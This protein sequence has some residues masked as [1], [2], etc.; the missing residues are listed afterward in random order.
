MALTEKQKEDLAARK[1]I[2]EAKRA[3]KTTKAPTKKTV[4]A[5]KSLA[6][7]IEA[8]NPTTETVITPEVMA[9]SEEAMDELVAIGQEIEQGVVE[10]SS[11]SIT[12]VLEQEATNVP[13][14]GENVSTA[15]VDSLELI[16]NEV[17]LEQVDQLLNKMEEVLE[18]IQEIHKDFSEKLDITPDCSIDFTNGRSK[19]AVYVVLG[20]YGTKEGTYFNEMMKEV[21]YILTLGGKFDRSVAPRFS[22]LPFSCKMKVPVDKYSD[23]VNR[24]GYPDYEVDKETYK[25]SLSAPD[26][27]VLLNSLEKYVE[28]GFEIDPN[29]ACLYKGRYVIPFQLRFPVEITAGLHCK[30]RTPIKYTVEEL[31]E[32][33]WSQV[34]S[35]AKLHGIEDSNHNAVISQLMTIMENI[36]D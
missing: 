15:S 20:G 2:N 31:R 24:A 36:D 19:P 6:E 26:F 11:E 7:Q 3:K 8:E 4:E 30:L 25:V 9:K 34:K 22:G 1:A 17:G 5:T 32:M 16:S 12:D 10:P 29:Q 21:V 35:I 27:R 13:P 28:Q 14:E 23:Y 18:N 33:Q